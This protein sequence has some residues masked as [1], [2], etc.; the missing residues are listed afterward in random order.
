M[1][2]IDDLKRNIK[3]LMFDQYGTV[4][5]MQGGLIEVATPFLQ[6]KGWSGR[7]AG[8]VRHVVATHAFR[9]LD[10]RRAA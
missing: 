6:S 3:L 4:V 5:D 8:R 7:P 9:E 10:D 1:S 2:T